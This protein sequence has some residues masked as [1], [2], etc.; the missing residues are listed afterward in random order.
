MA[1]D[2]FYKKLVEYQ[3]KWEVLLPDLPPIDAFLDAITSHYAGRPKI[4]VVKFDDYICKTYPSYT[5]V[6][7]SL[8]D[9]IKTRYGD[10]AMRL[11]KEVL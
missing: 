2:T 10:S 1:T 4:D 8:A 3:N 11:V 5:V 7:M 9:F 6:E